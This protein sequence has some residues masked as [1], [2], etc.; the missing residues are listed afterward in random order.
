MLR[1][2]TCK[3]TNARIHNIQVQE[4]MV[5]R[6]NNGYGRHIMF[7]YYDIIRVRTYMILHG[8]QSFGQQVS[9]N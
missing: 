8:K 4:Y 1:N 9:Q 7:S 2:T 3:N 5:T 6:P